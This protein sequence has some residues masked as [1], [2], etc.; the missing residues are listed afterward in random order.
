MK[1]LNKL[2]GYSQLLCNE[3]KQ[4]N[5]DDFV[6]KASQLYKLQIK[7]INQPIKVGLYF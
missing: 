2:C 1:V 5:F 7:N 4:N 6:K 3:N